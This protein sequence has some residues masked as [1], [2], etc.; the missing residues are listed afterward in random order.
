MWLEWSFKFYDD[1]EE[2]QVVIT[3]TTSTSTYIG[4]KKIVLNSVNHSIDLLFFNSNVVGFVRMFTPFLFNSNLTFSLFV[5]VKDVETNVTTRFY[6]TSTT[7]LYIAIRS[8]ASLVP[9]E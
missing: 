7:I 1:D 9:L 3:T 5:H 4:M 8:Y 2:E 6:V